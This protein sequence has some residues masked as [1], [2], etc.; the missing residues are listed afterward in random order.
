[1]EQAN[2]YSGR[3]IR[4]TGGFI[5]QADDGPRYRLTLLRTPIDEVEKRVVVTGV[6]TGDDQIEA[7]GVRL[8][9]ES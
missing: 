9:S 2:E 6:L 8:A 1:M 3:L 5:L 7:E 4:D